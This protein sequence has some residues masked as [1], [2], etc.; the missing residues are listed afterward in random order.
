MPKI[1]LTDK[2]VKAL[3]TEQAQEDF[4]DADF[5]IKGGSFGVRLTK[6]GKKTFFC[7]YRVRGRLKR[8]SLGVYPKTGL[9]EARDDAIKEMKGDAKEE[10]TGCTFEK[11]T[12]EYITRYAEKKKRPRSV[13]E[14]K[15]IIKAYLGEWKNARFM[16]IRKR[17]VLRLLEKV[18]KGRGDKPAPVMRNRVQAL[19]S[20]MF[21]FALRADIAPETW[22]NPCRLIE[23]NK[24]KSRERVLGDEEIKKI[25]EV[26]TAR[27][28]AS[29]RAYLLILAT[30]QRG[31]EVRAMRWD[32]IDKEG[33]WTIPPEMSKN[34]KE[35]RVP[36]STQALRIL[37]TLKP[38]TGEGEWV[39][40]NA[41][42][43]RSKAEGHV[44]WFGK[45]NSRL[46]KA[47]GFHFTPHDL[48]RTAATKMS[49]IGIPDTTIA[50]I[51]NRVWA[52]KNITASVYNRHSHLPEMK[53]AL[54]RWGAR[55]D[56]IVQG[57]AAKVVRIG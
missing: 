15:R 2:T 49:E 45:K 35:H 8:K 16:E 57:K 27:K 52:T 34:G 28:D 46:Q 37:D 29:S 33:V 23:A 44:R 39:F 24:E 31:G 3:K 14:D 41:A 40:P 22:A 1:T 53:V 36:L 10:R 51:L 4:F 48:R 12:E 30:G 56:Q 43:G 6:E 32:R 26:L 20:T 21:N 18:E 42:L 25:W 47:L 7:L 11:L 13:A 19:L 17:D 9:A 54:E 50:R 38:I 5:G 55:L